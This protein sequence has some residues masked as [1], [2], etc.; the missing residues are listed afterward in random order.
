[1]IILYKDRYI[2][3]YEDDNNDAIRYKEE[4]TFEI[5]SKPERVIGIKDEVFNG[6]KLLLNIDLPNTITSVGESVF[7]KSN[8]NKIDIP[9]SVKTI[10][11]SSFTFCRNLVSVK[12]S[13][14]LAIVAELLFYGCMNLECIDIPDSVV[15]IDVDAFSLCDKLN[16]VKLP[17]N[18][19]VIDASAFSYCSSL[20]YI[21]IPE[22]VKKI[23]QC[24]FTMCGNLVV[25]LPDNLNA[26]IGDYAFYKCKEIRFKS[27]NVFRQLDSDGKE[28]G[29]KTV[30][31][32]YYQDKS[33]YSSEELDDFRTFILENR[34]A[35]FEQALDNFEI[36][37]FMFKEIECVYSSSEIGDLAVKYC[38][39]YTEVTA[40][41]MRYLF[42]KDLIGSEDDFELSDYTPEEL[43]QMNNKNNGED[44]VIK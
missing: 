2:T 1:M 32:N 22:T 3:G 31:K 11:R 26:K 25:N 14:N 10:G 43:E 5:S 29:F 4:G 15:L 12:L 35:I 41:L 38:H 24:A 28:L 23:G 30:I 20:T 9:D 36:L 39:N 19:E 42:D 6:C 13:N 8:L 33:Y 37:E 40:Y 21:D 16:S 44:R 7:A 34:E 18:L 27:Y 17:K